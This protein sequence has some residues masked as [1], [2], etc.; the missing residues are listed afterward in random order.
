ME[1][2]SPPDA[3]PDNDD[4]NFT[5]LKT[6]VAFRRIKARLPGTACRLCG[7]KLS[8]APDRSVRVFSLPLARV[9]LL[10]SSLVY[11]RDDALVDEAA[12]VMERAQARFPITSPEYAAET[13][14][15]EALIVQS[16]RLIKDKVRLHGRRDRLCELST[17]G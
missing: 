4:P 15:A 5:S 3:L 17:P 13:R 2:T 10:M 6:C 7:R 14:R 12:H 9:S 8:R 11:E 1:T 16:E